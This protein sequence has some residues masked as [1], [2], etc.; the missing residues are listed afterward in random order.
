MLKIQNHSSI[1]KQTGDIR[2]LIPKKWDL[3]KSM[4]GSGSKIIS[5]CFDNGVFLDI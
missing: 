4:S 1:R 3:Q 2:G 5:M